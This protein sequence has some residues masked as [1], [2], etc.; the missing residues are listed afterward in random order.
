[1]TPTPRP[2]REKILVEVWASLQEVIEAGHG[3]VEIT[4]V[5]H[6]VVDVVETVRRRLNK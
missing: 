3:R 2:Q 1:M 5:D 6:E 4:V